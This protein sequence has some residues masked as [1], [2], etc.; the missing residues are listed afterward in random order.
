M[1]LAMLCWEDLLYLWVHSWSRLH[2]LDFSSALFAVAFLMGLQSKLREPGISQ[3]TSWQKPVL[4]LS[5]FHRN[6]ISIYICRY[7]GFPDGASSKEPTCQ[8]RRCKGCGFDPWVETMP[9]R[10]AWQPTPVFLPGESRGQRSLGGYSLQVC[11]ESDMT[12][13]WACTQC[14]DSH[15]Y[16][17]NQMFIPH[18]L[19]FGGRKQM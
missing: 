2:R 6:H 5:L 1:E 14:L 7:M 17:F 19:H 18:P 9:W 10:R 8:C 12:S 3:V 4:E 16:S 11:K 15:I 13:D